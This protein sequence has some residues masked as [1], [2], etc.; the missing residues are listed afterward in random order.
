LKTPTSLTPVRHAEQLTHAQI[1]RAALADQS[2]S[3]GGS[4]A[5][6]KVAKRD[7]VPTS[8]NLLKQY[9]SFTELVQACA[10][11]SEKVIA[12]AHRETRR[13]LVDML[14]EER[15]RLHVL[16]VEVQTSALG[17]TQRRDHQTIRVGVGALL[18]ARRPAGR[19]VCCRVVGDELVSWAAPR[20]A[21]VLND[22]PDRS[23]LDCG[24]S[25]LHARGCYGTRS[26]NRTPV[27]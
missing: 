4:E 15:P 22:G 21:A 3:K 27:V 9:A 13:S 12:R 17:R 26:Q 8:A 5:T 7:L 1:R 14:S 16:P 10:V 6:V 24:G 25:D 19:E 2:E 18:H 11:F 23:C 20:S